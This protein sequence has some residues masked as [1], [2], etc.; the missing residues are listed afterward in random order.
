MPVLQLAEDFRQ[1]SSCR[2]QLL[3]VKW[4]AIGKQQK[5][6]KKEEGREGGRREGEGR[7][8]KGRQGRG[9]E[10]RKE[11]TLLVSVQQWPEVAHS[12]FSRERALHVKV[13]LACGQEGRQAHRREIRALA[14]AL[15]KGPRNWDVLWKQWAC[16]E[17]TRGGFLWGA[18]N[19]DSDVFKSWFILSPRKHHHHKHAGCQGPAEEL[20]AELLLAGRAD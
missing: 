16:V 17:L 3:T 13:W 9:G 1:S 7:E 19:D 6:R 2:K 20:H 4:G 5:E 12:V 8:G 14:H 15:K 10:G 11:V 18:Q